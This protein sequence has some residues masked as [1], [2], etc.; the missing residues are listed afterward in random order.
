MTDLEKLR[1]TK[2]F[3]DKLA[4]GVNPLNDEPVP[5]SDLL[6][7]VRISRCMFYVSDILRKLIDGE[8]FEGVSVK[9]TGT[10]NKPAFSIS[11]EQLNNFAFSDIP[12]SAS[13][14]SRRL[15][16]AAG[17]PDMNKLTYAKLT[18]WLYA[19]GILT[20]TNGDGKGRRIPTELGKSLGITLE[21]R[22]SL[23]GEYDAVVYDRA[24][25]QFIIDNIDS[26]C[27]FIAEN[28]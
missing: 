15:F 23:H 2:D 25:Q 9:K 27:T 24:A 16:E 1:Y 12:L 26:L 5:E 13:E 8:A 18:N 10:K 21:H 14:L 3:I 20:D 28:A 19:R 17:N 22:N 4:D 7:N 11:Q 6:S